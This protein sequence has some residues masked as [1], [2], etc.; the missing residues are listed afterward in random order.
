MFNFFSFCGVLNIELP[1][2]KSN[3]TTTKPFYLAQPFSAVV[4]KTRLFSLPR[5]LRN[6][7]SCLFSCD[8]VSLVELPQ[9]KSG[10]AERKECKCFPLGT[11]GQWYLSP[12]KFECKVTFASGLLLFTPFPEP[13]TGD[14]F[15]AESRYFGALSLDHMTTAQEINQSGPLGRSVG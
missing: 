3:L 6:S 1:K 14:S 5:L 15:M 7:C 4:L 9:S 2:Y 13:L 12:G 11:G 10:T 8:V